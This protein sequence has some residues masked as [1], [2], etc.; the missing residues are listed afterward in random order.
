MEITPLNLQVEV[1]GI[2]EVAGGGF[3]LNEI[4]L[5][6]L[7]IDGDTSFILEGGFANDAG[8]FLAT[9]VL[10]AW[11][12]PRPVYGTGPGQTWDSGG[13]HAFDRY[14]GQVAGAAEAL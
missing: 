11:V 12:T 3:A 7:I 6:K 2:L 5:F 13:Q 10:P 4:V 1:G 8:A 14:G 9:N